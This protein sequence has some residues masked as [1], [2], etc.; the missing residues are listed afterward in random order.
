MGTMRKLCWHLLKLGLQV[1]VLDR[2]VADFLQF[3]QF[4]SLTREISL[5]VAESDK[6][7]ILLAFFVAQLWQLLWCAFVGFEDFVDV[8]QPLLL[9]PEAVRLT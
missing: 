3:F 9:P 7:T 5:S 8:L 1:C 4:L 6:L 2:N